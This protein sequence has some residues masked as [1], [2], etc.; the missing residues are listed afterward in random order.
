MT[1]ESLALE[2]RVVDVAV[3]LVVVVMVVVMGRPMVSVGGVCVC[4]CGDEF[5]KGGGK[6]GESSYDEE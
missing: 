2:A 1:L 6:G 5:V 4:V 3:D